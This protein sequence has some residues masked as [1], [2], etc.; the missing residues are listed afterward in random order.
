MRFSSVE[1]FG[2]EGRAHLA[3]GPVALI[4]AEDGVE[5][6]STLAHFAGLGFAATVVLH[7]PG[8]EMPAEAEG[9]AQVVC[10][11][12]GPG[13]GPGGI[14]ATLSRIFAAAPT[15]TW[16]YW[17]FNAEYL[18]F[19]FCETRSVGEL[20]AF[21]GEERRAAMMAS[22]V[23]LYAG[24]LD[25]FPDGV[26]RGAPLYDG[27][28]YYALDRYGADGIRLERQ[29]D[30][31]GGLRWRFEDHVPWTRR[32]ID[33]VALVQTAPGLVMR[34]DLTLSDEERNT[35]A[36]PWHRNLTAAILSFRAAKA[37]RS[38]PRSRPLVR[39]F[40]WSGSAPFGW[41]SRELMERGLME[42]GQW[43]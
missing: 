23:D 35:S 13:D 33:R 2:R 27:R 21:H 42:P 43:F 26:D 22:V 7:P 24:D 41:T 11:M 1:A 16:I 18:F 40:R 20:L 34:P 10:D 37:L 15:G 36:C 14:A 39:D 6:G 3:K 28:G 25:R 29:V 30:I 4:F 17:G 38:S 5:L 32:R 12:D 9:L 31:F 19:P 8:L